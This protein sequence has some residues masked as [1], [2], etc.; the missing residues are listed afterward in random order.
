MLGKNFSTFQRQCWR[1]IRSLAYYLFRIPPLYT[2]TKLM[3]ALVDHIRSDLNSTPTSLVNGWA[4]N[5]CGRKKRRKS[6]GSP[7]AKR[8][9]GAAAQGVK[10]L[11]N[12]VTREAH[13]S[14]G[15]DPTTQRKERLTNMR[16][17][18]YQGELQYF[19]C[20]LVAQNN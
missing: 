12:H 5:T 20:F 2:Y 14:S 18:Q 9:C 19:C 7:F 11:P 17:R 3:E 10:L 16:R 6:G 8:H 4:V 1:S 15:R 13:L